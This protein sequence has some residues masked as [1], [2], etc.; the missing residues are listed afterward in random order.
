MAKK[1]V[2]GLVTGD[3]TK[4]IPAPEIDYMPSDPKRYNPPIGLIGCGGISQSHLASYKRAGYNVVA[5]CDLIPE[6]AENR[7]K[8]F[9][10]RAKTYTDYKEL[11]KRDDIEVVDIATHPIDREYLIPAALNAG[12]HVLSQKP[13][14]LDLDKG[15][16][17]SELADKKGVKLA[18]NQNGRWAPHFAYMRNAVAKGYIGEVTCAHLDC[19]WDHDW[20]APTPF[21]DVHHIILYDY[22]IHWFDILNCFMMGKPATRV[23]ASIVKAKGQTAKPPLLGQALIEYA[24]AQATLVFDG[25][26][27]LG[28]EDTTF[29][30]GTKGTLKSAGTGI[31]GGQTVTLYTTKGVAT[32][33]PKGEWFKDGFHGSMAALL[34]AI[35][36]NQ[37]PYNNPEQNLQGLA[38]C[39]AAVRSADTGKPQIPGKVRK[40]AK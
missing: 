38:T 7:R 32:A 30:A 10:P 6:R 21:N 1:K 19:R 29:L 39:F 28:M 4:K 20:I 36:K 8:E 40:I 37:K 13:F 26:V 25:Y 16:R 31:N 27:K 14:V 12:K 34:T 5:L 18:I 11:L 17:F 2:Y 23:Y 15:Y 9:Y 33:K 35:A 3:H 22:A 24:D